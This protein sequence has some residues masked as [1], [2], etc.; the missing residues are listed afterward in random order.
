M[1]GVY[2]METVI[3]QVTIPD[4]TIGEAT[5]RNVYMNL[6]TPALIEQAIKRHEGKLASNGALV[7]Y[8]GKRTGRSPKDRFIVH[9]AATEALVHWNQINQPVTRDVYQAL[10]DRVMA[11]LDER[12]IFVL[13]A[14]VGADLRTTLP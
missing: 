6:T 11:Y 9:N 3:K 10:R 13:D 14:R 12:D 2:Q 4:E 8:T 1:Q 7:A 5:S